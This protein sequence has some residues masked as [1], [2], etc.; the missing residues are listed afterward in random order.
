MNSRAVRCCQPATAAFKLSPELHGIYPG[1][2]TIQRL[3]AEPPRLIIDWKGG[4]RDTIDITSL[5]ASD[6]LFAVLA[7]KAVFAAV[8]IIDFGIAVGW[9]ERCEL[10]GSTLNADSGLQTP[11]NPLPSGL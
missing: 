8:E 9:H 4:G 7:D 10:S 1:I 6:P 11:I 3:C 5:I 2:P